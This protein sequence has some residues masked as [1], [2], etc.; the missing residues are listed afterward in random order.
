MCSPTH[1]HRATAEQNGEETGMQAGR[2]ATFLASPGPS[3]LPFPPWPSTGSQAHT[4]AHMSCGM[5]HVRFLGSMGG[6]CCKEKEIHSL[7]LIQSLPVRPGLISVSNP[8][9]A[10]SWDPD[11]CLFEVAKSAKAQR[12]YEKRSAVVLVMPRTHRKWFWS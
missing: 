2:Q 8:L 4:F 10:L 1:T 6:G 7:F 12:D 3:A 5:G 11:Y 9:K